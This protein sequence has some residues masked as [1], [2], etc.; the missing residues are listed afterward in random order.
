MKTFKLLLMIVMTSMAM[1]ATAQQGK[2]YNLWPDGAPNTNL[3]V[4]EAATLI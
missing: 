4:R 1:S 3:S 2:T